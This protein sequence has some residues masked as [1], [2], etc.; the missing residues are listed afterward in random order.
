MSPLTRRGGPRDG[1]PFPVVVAYG[2]V[3]G[4]PLIFESRPESVALRYGKWFRNDLSFWST[5]SPSGIGFGHVAVLQASFSS[6]NLLG[7][8][9]APATTRRAMSVTSSVR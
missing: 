1:T 4:N 8:A 5:P 6:G 3:G 7:S 9:S 2:A